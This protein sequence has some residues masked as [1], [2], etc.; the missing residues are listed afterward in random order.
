MAVGQAHNHTSGL[1]RKLK[2]GFHS[3]A[4]KIPAKAFIVASRNSALSSRPTI[5]SRKIGWRLLKTLLFARQAFVA[6]RRL[7]CEKSQLTPG[8]GGT[9]IGPLHEGLTSSVRE[10]AHLRLATKPERLRLQDDWMIG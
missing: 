6:S 4:C 10:Q 5:L 3:L 9:F 8:P 7:S 1:I 2:K